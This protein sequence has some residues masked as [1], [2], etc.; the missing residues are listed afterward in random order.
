[1]ERSKTIISIVVGLAGLLII[2]K[3]GFAPLPEPTLTEQPEQE[4]VT[5]ADA[6]ADQ[7]EP[8]PPTERQQRPQR[9]TRG[10]MFDPNMTAI[11]ADANG[12]QR[13]TRFGRRGMGQQPFGGMVSQA[14]QT[15]DPNELV[16]VNLNGVDLRVIVQTLMNW[17]GKSIIPT[18]GAENVRLTVF[19]QQMLPKNEALDLLYK[20]LR[21]QGYVTEDDGDTIYIKPISDI[22]KIDSAPIIDVDTPLATIQD[23]EKI[24]QKFFRLKNTNPTQIAQILYQ[25]LGDS[26]FISSDDSTGTLLVIDTVRTLMR[27]ELLINMYDIDLADTF[28]EIFEI[29][30]RDPEEMVEMLET[31][32]SYGGASGG[33][34]PM[35]ML[36]NILNRGNVEG[37]V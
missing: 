21:V 3:V 36:G 27:A 12:T 19:A 30:H 13:D 35:N 31:I 5:D 6:T 23:R 24:V 14:P 4:V 20:A 1:M 22:T 26:C 9:G 18:S 37:E 28:T 16:P 7:I 29:R 32:I 11:V 33:I 34:D 8:A 2:W 15:S 25:L 10:G 17:T